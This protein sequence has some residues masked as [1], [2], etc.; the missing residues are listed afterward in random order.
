MSTLRPQTTQ[1]QI[2][3]A[4]R[5]FR[6]ER[7]GRYAEALDE[8][9]DI[10]PDLSSSPYLVD[11]E[12]DVSA[13][14]LL[15]CG[16]LIG[17]HGHCE[18][19]AGSQEKSRDLLMDARG[20]FLDRSDIEKAAECENYLALS[21]WRTGEHNE[22]LIWIKESFSRKL[23][24]ANNIRL[25]SIIIRCLINIPAKKNLQNLNVLKA[26]ETEFLACGDDCLTGDFF[27]HCGIALD[28]LG[29]K[30]EALEHFEFAKYY[31]QRSK[32]RV[33]LATVENNLAWLYKE[34]GQFRK[35]HDAIDN[36]IR[37]FKAVRDKTREGFSLDTKASLYFAEKKYAE[38]LK[39]V[40]KAASI[41]KRSENSTYLIET[42]VTKAKVL[43]HLDNFSD[44]V[45][46]LI[47][48]VNMA[49]IQTG[50]DAARRVIKEFEESLKSR[51]S[52]A[53][54]NTESSVEKGSL[55]MILPASIGNY[56]DYR[57]VWINNDELEEIGLVKGSLAV[58]AET[59]VKRGDL[60]A[61]SEIESGAVRCGFYDA[62]FGI[63][64]IE[65]VDGEPEVFD[66][67]EV[68]ILGKIVG[69][70]PESTVR[71]G[72]KL[73]VEALNV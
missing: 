52:V 72:G 38:A 16:S 31:H 69:V 64:C 58:V 62:D 27:N 41:L 21:Y 43:L 44:A 53:A 29:R 73:T 51:N 45:V 24:R 30:T 18:Q 36:A 20:R 35:A 19:E 12:P 59:P 34:S 7:S 48:A 70:C 46:N 8:L 63:V 25:F 28:N 23:P 60:A 32:H 33:Y 4:A 54:K 5:L 3:L 50:E 61:V 47:D 39:T 67:S 10:W 57:G 22:A 42:L 17:F 6:L 37:L 49:R 55:E 11:V 26:V 14:L 56:A 2:P 66:E 13:E 9:A 68:R 15:R 71:K 40:N 65:S 1:T